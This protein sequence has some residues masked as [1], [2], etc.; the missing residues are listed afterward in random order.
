VGWDFCYGDEAMS[1]LAFVIVC[2][3]IAFGLIVTGLA[4]RMPDFTVAGSVLGCLA[5]A[6][7]VRWLWS[8]D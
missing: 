7:S 2:D 5:F 6:V 1:R 3:V 8:P 4:S